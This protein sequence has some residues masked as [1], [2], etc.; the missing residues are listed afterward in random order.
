MPGIRPSA[1]QLKLGASGAR[2]Y[3]EA[4]VKRLAFKAVSKLVLQPWRRQ[5]HGLTLGTR[6]VAIEEG[7]VLLVR[8]SYAPG[9]LFPGG[10]VDRGETIYEAALR[11]VGEETGVIGLEEP[12]L[13]GVFLNDKQFRGDHVACFI[14]RRFERKPK[15]S[16]EIAEAKFFPLGSLP[17]AT[18]GGTRRR[19]AEIFSAAEIGRNW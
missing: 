6:I 2:F 16:L 18:T 12:V 8:H 17:D 7:S 13:H 11:E 14:L 15:R 3:H 5:T 19:I 1:R 10:G 4:M 9:W